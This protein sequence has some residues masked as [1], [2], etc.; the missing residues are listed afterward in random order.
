MVS[1]SCMM[2]LS[3]SLSS[4]HSMSTDCIDQLNSTSEFVATESIS[5]LLLIVNSDTAVAS[6]CKCAFNFSPS[7]TSIVTNS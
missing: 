5:A 7:A 2:W 4:S 6:C 1:H 3:N